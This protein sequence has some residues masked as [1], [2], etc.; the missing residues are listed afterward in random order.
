VISRRRVPSSAPFRSAPRALGIAIA[1]AG[2]LTAGC[3]VDS[4][5]QPDDPDLSAIAF[6]YATDSTSRNLDIYAVP[7]DGSTVRRIVTSP[8]IE[9]YPDWSPDGQT[10]LFTRISRGTQ[11]DPVQRASLWT[12]RADGTE[13]RELTAGLGYSFG[14]RWSPDGQSIVFETGEYPAFSIG[15]MRADGTGWH[16]VASASVTDAYSQPTWSPDGRIAFQRTTAE[17]RGIWTMSSDGSG[18]IRLT[19]G[20]DSEP[21]WSPDGKQL[22]FSRQ[23]LS[24]TGSASVLVVANADGSELR[25]LTG[26]P[27]DRIPA[28]SPDGKVIIYDSQVPFGN[29][30]SCPLYKVFAAGSLPV[31]FLPQRTRAGC[32]GSAWRA[33]PGAS[34]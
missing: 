14:G 6:A 22:V 34:K 4:A 13:L 3:G 10:L 8:E 16:T 27:Y 9:A 21:R 28:W 19:G 12:V 2:A 32:S 30:T 11:Q 15:V 33:S 26:G 24:G 5:T 31:N 7:V 17:W 20:D 29:R 18:L 1:L 25:Q 23:F